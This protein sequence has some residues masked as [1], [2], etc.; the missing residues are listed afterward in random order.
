M[1][2]FQQKL[3]L[4]V[5]FFSVFLMIFF[6][7]EELYKSKKSDEIIQKHQAVNEKIIWEIEQKKQEELYKTTNNYKDKY[8][9]ETLGKLNPGEQVFIIPP[10]QTL[11]SFFTEEKKTN[12]EIEKT[13]LLDWKRYF[14][15][16]R[17][18]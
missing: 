7:S 8:A 12:T 6:L 13:P 1:L 5:L 16:S 4:S 18:F 9:K 10:K 17:D 11:H 14:F 2:S 15:H 3:I